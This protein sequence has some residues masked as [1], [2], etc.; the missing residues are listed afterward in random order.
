MTFGTKTI[1][2][3]LLLPA[4][5]LW[6]VRC[7]KKDDSGNFSAKDLYGK[8]KCNKISTLWKSKPD[9]V[10]NSPVGSQGI[11]YRIT[12]DSIL[13]YEKTDS[14]RCYAKSSI[15]VAYSTNPADT[16]PHDSTLSIQARQ[17]AEGIVLEYDYIK[18]DSIREYCLQKIDTPSII[19]VCDY[20]VMAF[21]TRKSDRGI[22]KIVPVLVRCT[23]GWGASRNSISWF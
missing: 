21:K 8:W 15:A 16:A 13:N 4:M 5:V 14:A 6:N 7:Q 1:V 10:V 2:F 3:I 22:R 9:S 17:S 18:T 20:G 19:N 11:Y 12:A 23:D